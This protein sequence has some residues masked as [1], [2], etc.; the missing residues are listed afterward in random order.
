M[1]APPTFKG[2]LL[3]QELIIF[4]LIQILGLWAGIRL[5]LIVPL[6]EISE[7]A[8]FWEFIIGFVLATALLIIFLRILKGN[9]FF[10][11][12]FVL[13]L[14]FGCFIIFNIFIF[15]A[16]ALFLAVLVLFLRFIFPKVWLHNLVIGLAAAGIGA[17][18]GLSFPPTTILIIIFILSL[19]DYIAVYKT[20]HM[21][22][23]FRELLAKKVIFAIILPEKFKGWFADLRKIKSKIGFLFLGTGDIILPLILAVSSLN[24][25][26]ESA[27]FVAGGSLIGVVAL[28]ILFTTQPKRTPMPAL[29]PLAFFSVLGFL[30]SL[31]IK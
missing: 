19:Y 14:F 6:V 1:P 29:P 3:F 11:I 30:V 16:A 17:S 4:G 15:D 2:K 25:S 8:S 20:G 27:V 26:L 10:R 23:M 12:F 21:V 9:L 31:L 28:H 24:H 7:T 5:L 22:V 13:V 18:F